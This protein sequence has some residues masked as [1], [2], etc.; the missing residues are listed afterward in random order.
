IPA[1]TILGGVVGL[2]GLTLF[3]MYSLGMVVAIPVAW[4]LKKTL[5]R[6]ETPPFLLELPSYKWPQAGTVGRRVYAQGMEFLRRAG[7]IIFAIT[8]VV[9]ALSYFPRSEEITAAFDAKRAQAAA[10]LDGPQEAEA[11]AALDAQESGAHVRNSYIGRMGRM[12]EPV[13]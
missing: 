8:V 7:T 4:I 13:V 2:Q 5:L 1:R 6:G 3:G 12:I 11:L 10:A 9:W